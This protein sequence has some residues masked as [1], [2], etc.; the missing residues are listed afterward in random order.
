MAKKVKCIECANSSFFAL[1]HRVT[2]N[3]YDYAK[4]CLVVAKRSIYCGRVDKVKP[5]EHEQYCKHFFKGEFSYN[6][7]NEIARLEK[8]IEEYEIAESMKKELK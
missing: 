1:P 7:D 5:R 6:I 2:S 3:N 4:Y 8:M